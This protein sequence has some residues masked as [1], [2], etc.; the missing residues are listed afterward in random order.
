MQDLSGSKPN[1]YFAPVMGTLRPS[2][3]S[4][5]QTAKRISAA[6]RS[7]IEAHIIKIIKSSLEESGKQ[8]K[9]AAK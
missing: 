8:N 4:H 1:K 2:N 6:M 9:G 7:Q 3:E 5:E